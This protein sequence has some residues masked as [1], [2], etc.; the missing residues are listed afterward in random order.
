MNTKWLL[1]GL[2]AFA[3]ACGGDDSKKSKGGDSS[4]TDC[5]DGA[6]SAELNVGEPSAPLV[7]GAPAITV[8]IKLNRAP[9]SDVTVNIVSLSGEVT[10]EPSEMT[11]TTDTFSTTQLLSLSAADDNEPGGDREVTIEFSLVSDDVSF[12]GRPVNPLVITV[13]EDDE[14]PSFDVTSDNGFELTEDGVLELEVALSIQPDGDVLVP[15]E[16]TDE[17][18][19]EIDIN[20]LMFGELN[21]NL[22]QTITL[23]GIDDGE[24]D[25]DQTFNMVFGP[26]N[27]TGEIYNGAPNF[28]VSIVSVDGVCGNG[29]IDGNEACEPSGSESTEC[30][31]GEESCTY[32]TDTCQEMAGSVIG[33][34]GDGQVQSG[35]EQCDEAPTR[36]PYGQMSCQS[37]NTQCQ[38]GPGELTGYCG[39]GR[40]QGA[41]GEECDFASSACCDNNCKQD[42][43]SCTPDCLIISE[44][45]EAPGDNKAIEI[46]NCGSATESLGQIDICLVRNEAT[47]CSTSFQFTGNIAPGD[48]KVLC[49][50]NLNYPDGNAI[51]DFRNTNVPSFNGDD[52]LALY[53]DTDG[54]GSFNP[55]QDV[56]LDA[57]GQLSTEP[58]SSWVDVFY[59]RCNFTPFDGMSSFD[60]DSY[61]SQRCGVG[62]LCNYETNFSAT[63]GKPPTQGCN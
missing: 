56:I 62:G 41:N 55:A 15:V 57:F 1:I 24:A 12:A 29:T 46:Y 23:T 30:E 9:T 42:L 20:Q 47:T 28:S 52:R 43:S 25:G 61:Y 17:S 36:C 45:M 60:V 53:V 33:F 48:T 14:A 13:V 49:H 58:L 2:L 5:P 32:C 63:F 7:E 3:V 39:D 8:P 51:C 18:E 34:C 21:W 11:F 22:P 31:Y 35:F 44:Y 50:S 26:V 10:A 40:V 27:S 37:C 19:A 54:N 4:C 16:I 38:L 59:D 6:G